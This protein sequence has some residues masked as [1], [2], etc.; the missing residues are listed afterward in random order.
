MIAIIDYGVGNLFSLQSSFRA[1][2]RKDCEDILLADRRIT[3]L[4]LPRAWEGEM[5]SAASFIR[6]KAASVGLN[7][8]AFCCKLEEWGMIFFRRLICMKERQ[9]GCTGRLCAD[10][11]VQRESGGGRTG[12]WRRGR[13][14]RPSGGSGGR[15][16]RRNAQS[17]DAAS[18]PGKHGAFLRGRRRN[19][20]HGGDRPI[21]AGRAGSR[22]SGYGGGENGSR[23]WESGGADTETGSPWGWI[24]GTDLWP[25]ADGR[26]TPACLLDFCREN[27]ADGSED[28]DLHRYFQGRRHAGHQ[29]GAVQG[30]VRNSLDCISRHPAEF[31]PWRM[32]KALREMNLYG[33]IIG[34]AYY[35]GRY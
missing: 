9:S 35:T 26:K 19:P 28:S 11:R 29:P 32:W 5:Y 25:S 16:I 8:E 22:D 21:S 14:P 33:A 4:I 23:F 31:P 2:T 10:D 13:H 30:T 34:K 20:Q 7:S 15:P 1:P 18:N 6:K 17:G 3:G 27:A 12:L 24:S